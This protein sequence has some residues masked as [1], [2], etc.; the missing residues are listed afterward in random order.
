MT[1]EILG[2]H[3]FISG[4]H[5]E[6]GLQR[7]GAVPAAQA[8]VRDLHHP[9]RPAEE[10]VQVLFR[11]LCQGRTGM[12]EVIVKTLLKPLLQRLGQMVN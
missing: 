10:A 7:V 5:A 4:M 9:D 8:G 3:I 1:C 11:E 2:H 12:F 6:V